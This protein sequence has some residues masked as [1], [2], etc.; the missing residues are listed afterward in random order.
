VV[1]VVVVLLLLLLPGL[2][3]TSLLAIEIVARAPLLLPAMVPCALCPQLVATRRQGIGFG[4]ICVLPFKR[5]TAQGE[6][7]RSAID[8]EAAALGR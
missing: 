7:K 6:K 8:R 1:V 4:L 5:N 2:Q 3:H